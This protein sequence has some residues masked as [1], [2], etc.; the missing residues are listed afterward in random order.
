MIR[1][2]AISG[3]AGAGKSS[4]ARQ[5][6]ESLP[7]HHC[8]IMS[9]AGPL[10]AGCELE[11]GI[12][13]DMPG[14]REALARYGDEKRAEDPDYFIKLLDVTVDSLL[15][16]GR[17]P[18]IDD[19][20]LADEYEHLTRLGFYRLRVVAPMSVRW[21]RVVARGDDPA[22]VT[23]DIRYETELDQHEFDHKLYNVGPLGPLVES[24]ISDVLPPVHPLLSSAA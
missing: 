8:G 4:V 7:N 22:I 23:S 11:W 20:R 12:T 19:L 16:A 21:D 6:A 13:K 17:L 9:Y 5:L 10:K 3:K 2:I 24:F 14:G 1:G 15:E 18:I